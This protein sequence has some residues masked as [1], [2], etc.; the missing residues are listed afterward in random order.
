[1]ALNLAGADALMQDHRDAIF[2]RSAMRIRT[3]SGLMAAFATLAAAAPPPRPG[4]ETA[5][6]FVGS[7][8]VLDWQAAGDDSLYVRGYNGRWYFVRTMGRCPRLVDALTLGFVASAA[9]QL[10]RHGT[11]LAEGIRCPVDS[12]TYAAAP[13]P[14]KRRHRR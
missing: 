4:A 1:L 3:L 10:D 14:S 8:G 13:P 9:D 5:I 7:Q 2:W 11:V 6:P 12:V